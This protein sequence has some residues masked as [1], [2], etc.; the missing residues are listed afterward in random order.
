MPILFHVNRNNF[1]IIFSKTI[2]NIILHSLTLFIHSIFHF[3]NY[4]FLKN[5]F[6][7]LFLCFHHI[8]LNLK[9]SLKSETKLIFDQISNQEHVLKLSWFSDTTRP[10]RN[11]EEN[12]RNYY[13]ISH[14]EMMNDIH[15]NEYLE[16]GKYSYH[17]TSI[18]PCTSF[19]TF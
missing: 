3:Q 12:G 13:F 15:S 18:V 4:F 2:W 6:S 19:I 7:N 14:D 11:D 1:I 8:S 5:H 16:Y 17:I 10:P 9:P